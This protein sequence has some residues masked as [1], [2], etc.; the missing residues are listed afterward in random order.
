MLILLYVVSW[1]LLSPSVLLGRSPEEVT[2]H[3]ALIVSPSSSQS[4]ALE[5]PLLSWVSAISG[6]A[7]FCSLMCL[8]STYTPPPTAPARQATC[9][10]S[11][12]PPHL[13]A[14]APNPGPN[15]PIEVRCRCIRGRAYAV[16]VFEGIFGESVR[17]SRGACSF[18]GILYCD[19]R[20]SGNGLE[21]QFSSTA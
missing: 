18:A 20:K 17:A 14:T 15:S 7:S 4:E 16:V 1:C 8:P 9:A 19:E 6:R 3:F 21:S 10:I 13:G 5:C 12:N 11:A 2:I